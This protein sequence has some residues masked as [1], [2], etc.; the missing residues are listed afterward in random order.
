MAVRSLFVDNCFPNPSHVNFD[1]FRGTPAGDLAEKLFAEF[2]TRFDRGL[3]PGEHYELM[4]RHAEI[5]GL[6]GLHSWSP[7]PMFRLLQ[8]APSLSTVLTSLSIT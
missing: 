3:R 1:R 6:P 8:P 4:D 7:E 5:I 2:K